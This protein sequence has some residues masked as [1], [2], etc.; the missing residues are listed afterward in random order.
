MSVHTSGSRSDG[1]DRFTISCHFVAIAGVRPPSLLVHMLFRSGRSCRESGFV[2]SITGEH[3]PDD[4]SVLVG[5]RD[6]HDIRMPPL[7]HLA[8]PEAPWIL[9]ATS[10]TERNALHGL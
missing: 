3:R 4:P 6:G 9:L 5:K 2:I 8:E 7:P 10:F 1:G